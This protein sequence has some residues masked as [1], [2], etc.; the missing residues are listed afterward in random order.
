MRFCR[1][2]G[3]VPLAVLVA[4]ACPPSASAADATARSAQS[5]A[6][7][8]TTTPDQVP[9]PTPESATEPQVTDP[10]AGLRAN[11]LIARRY[12]P[13]RAKLPFLISTA[14]IPDGV[15]TER[16]VAMAETQGARWGL[17]PDG[18]TFDT[19]SLRNRRSEVGFSDRV[20]DGAL[21]VHHRRFL[22]RYRRLMRCRILANGSRSGCVTVGVRKLATI[23]TDRDI[24]LRRDVAWEIGPAW[25]EADEFD[26]QTVIIHEFGHFAGNEQHDANCTVA[27]MT[28]SLSPGDWWRS[29]LDHRVVCRKGA[30]SASRHAPRMS[31]PHRDVVTREYETQLVG[32]RR[33]G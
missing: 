7:P 4:F 18:V 1:S 19:A 27:P 3:L 25:P 33:A 12:G 14:D 9:V 29:T 17:R 10:A 13:R 30:R 22:V 8:P 20:P 24:L 21:G 26:L 2:V 11:E 32:D 15:D 28:P 16:F 23:V 5:P 31:F 6:P